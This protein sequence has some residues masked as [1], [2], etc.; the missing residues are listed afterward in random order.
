L[1]RF[2]FLPLAAVSA[3]QT[4]PFLTVEFLGYVI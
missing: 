4:L 1:D 2:G 3:G